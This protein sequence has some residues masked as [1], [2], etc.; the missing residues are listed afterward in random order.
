[1]SA[2]GGTRFEGVAVDKKAN[3]YFDGL[4]ISHS[5][6]FPDGSRKTIGVIQPST[7]HFG[8]AAAEIMEVLDGHCRVRLDGASDWQDHGAGSRF[9]V[10][11]NSGFDIETTETLHYVCHFG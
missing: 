6:H 2:S 4:C 3:V 9:S 7:L 11:A 1:M 8:T 5:V 10:P